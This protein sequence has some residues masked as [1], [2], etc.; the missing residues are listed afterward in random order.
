VASATATGDELAVVD[1]LAD[2]HQ[3]PKLMR[4]MS[5]QSCEVPTEIPVTRCS[6]RG[7]LSCGPAQGVPTEILVTGR[8]WRGGVYR[9]YLVLRRFR[10]LRPTG[11]PLGEGG[12]GLLPW[13]WLL[14]S[15]IV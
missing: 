6:W 10:A 1:I 5:I 4:S 8:F 13:R 9:R 7:G 11:V 2:E 3:L 15:G 14:L 12:A